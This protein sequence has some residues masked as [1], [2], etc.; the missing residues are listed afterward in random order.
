MRRSLVLLTA[1]VLGLLA[2]LLGH[3]G[4]SQE[5]GGAI[6]PGLVTTPPPDPSSA[7]VVTYSTREL[8]RSTVHIVTVP[9]SYRVSVGVAASLDTVAAIAQQSDA[10]AAIN[11]G[12]FDP[13]NGETTSYITVDGE[14]VATPRDNSRLM[15]NPD[16]APYLSKILNRSEFRRYRC[17][18]SQSGEHSPGSYAIAPH[19]EPPPVGCRTLDAVGGG[20]RLLPELTSVEEGFVAIAGGDRIR[21]A[22]GETRPNARSAIGITASGK[23]LLVAAAQRPELATSG[24][25]LR[26][27]ATLMEEL[28][29]VEALNLDGGSSTALY[30]QGH[31]SLGRWSESQWIE[32]PVKTALTVT[33]PLREGG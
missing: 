7:A 16:L 10:I 5:Q 23:L 33:A 29:A 14:E 20:P 2:A 9:A 1:I 4:M 26:E 21:D 6:A 28:G 24:L 11:A 31:L 13:Q 19:S 18:G 12:F 3:Q 30:Y 27:L 8:E 17:A 32:R 25:T 15:D 22:L